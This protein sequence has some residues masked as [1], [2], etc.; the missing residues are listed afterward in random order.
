MRACSLVWLS[1]RPALAEDGRLH[2]DGLKA[3]V[4]GI[5][6][7]RWRWRSG[8]STCKGA[9]PSM[10]AMI[11]VPVESLAAHVGPVQNANDDGTWK[12]DTNEGL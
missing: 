3:I 4:C 11:H 10:P 6:P 2:T 5:R 8:N 1:R 9:S 7:S 12:V